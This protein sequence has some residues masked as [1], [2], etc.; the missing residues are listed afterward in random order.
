MLCLSL[1]VASMAQGME[2]V[3]TSMPDSIFPYLNLSVRTDL[4]NAFKAKTKLETKNLLGGDCIVND[5]TD[6]FMDIRLNKMTDLKLLLLDRRDSTQMLCVARTYGSPAAESKIEFY[7]ADW[8]PV[9][10]RF[11]LP[12]TSDAR[13]ML[14]MLTCRP[15]T[16]T[17]Q[18]FAEIKKNIEPVMVAADLTPNGE[19]R[20]SL[21]VPLL[22][23][24]DLKAVETIKKQKSLKWC[25][26]TFK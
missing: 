1:A 24:E 25:G 18:R 4:V 23:K 20:F 9:G 21:S 26:D 3:F 12:D 11:G 5:M 16:M 14:S 2:E 10:G 6:R 15:D 22:Q 13:L 19:I 8:K 7:T 17:E